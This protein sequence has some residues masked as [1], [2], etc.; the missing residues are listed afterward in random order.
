MSDTDS[1]RRSA[2]RSVGLVVGG[3]AAGTLLGAEV[4]AEAGAEPVHADQAP[5]ISQQIDNGYTPG[6]LDLASD[7]RTAIVVTGN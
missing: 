3:L 1:G 6:R 5:S 7:R 2:R 4:S